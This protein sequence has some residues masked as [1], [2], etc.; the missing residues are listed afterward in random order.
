M[1][2]IYRHGQSASLHLDSTA[3]S[4][5]NLSSGLT[6]ATLSRSMDP[7]EVTNFG[8][9][10]DRE[11]IRGLRGATI[12]CSGVWSSTHANVLDGIFGDSDSSS[13]YSFEYQPESTSAGRH[14]LKGEAFMTSLEYGAS[15]G[16]AVSMNFDLMIT[17]PVT[18]TNN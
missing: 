6:E 5:V 3:G 14:L 16:D 18:S 8:S 10:C 11:Y 12:S 9:G 7:A 15:V 13:T 1:A 4:L 2:P 17:G